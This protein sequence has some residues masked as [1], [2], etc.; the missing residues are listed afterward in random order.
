MSKTVLHLDSRA[1]DQAMDE[2]LGVDVIV[3][4]APMYN[5]VFPSFERKES[6][7]AQRPQRQR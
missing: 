7:W 1:S 4:G 5:F 3:I 2:F 6:H